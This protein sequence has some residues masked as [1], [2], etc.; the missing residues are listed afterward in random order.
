MAG[1]LVR[2]PG[3][4]FAGGAVSSGRV[5]VELSQHR[6]LNARTPRAHVFHRAPRSRL[7]D[8]SA[9]KTVTVL[10]VVLHLQMSKLAAGRHRQGFALRA[11]GELSTTNF[12]QGLQKRVEE[13]EE[14]FYSVSDEERDRERR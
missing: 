11:L 3:H 2:A 12:S 14:N 7:G 5:G 13:G 6:T 8:R 1:V 9:R 4:S 10:V